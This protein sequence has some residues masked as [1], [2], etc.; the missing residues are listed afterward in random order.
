METL[1]RPKREILRSFISEVF[2]FGLG[3]SPSGNV[4]VH[5]KKNRD[6][7]P[8]HKENIQADDLFRKSDEII[9]DMVVRI[10]IVDCYLILVSF[11]QKQSHE[12]CF[13]EADCNS[14]QIRELRLRLAQ[15]FQIVVLREPFA[16][17]GPLGETKYRIRIM[18]VFTPKASS[19]KL[20]FESSGAGCFSTPIH[21]QEAYDHF[22]SSRH[23]VGSEHASDLLRVSKGVTHFSNRGLGLTSKTRGQVIIPQNVHYSACEKID[24]TNFNHEAILSVRN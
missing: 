22:G 18:Y 20:E 14:G 11:H 21:A 17:E 19:E 15:G 3:L 10:S 5:I 7:W 1:D 23:S 4:R 6:I 13:H 2:K 12:T 9:C 24:V 8:M 16:L